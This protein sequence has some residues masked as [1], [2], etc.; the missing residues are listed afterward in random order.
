MK[1]ESSVVPSFFARRSQTV[2]CKWR[3]LVVAISR[4]FSTWVGATVNA[5]ERSCVYLVCAALSFWCLYNPIT[6]LDRV[7]LSPTIVATGALR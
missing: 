7:C 6:P 3:L 4:E 1:R 5:V 2:D